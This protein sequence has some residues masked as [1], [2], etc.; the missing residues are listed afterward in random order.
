MAG[1]LKSTKKQRAHKVSKGIH[2]GGGKTTL[3][4]VQRVLMGKGAYVNIAKPA[5]GLEKV[6]S[7]ES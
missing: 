1:K 5:K 6:K 4:P 2:G 7:H 3:T